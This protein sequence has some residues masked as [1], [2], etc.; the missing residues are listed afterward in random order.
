VTSTKG[1]LNLEANKFYYIEVVASRAGGNLNLALNAKMFN[2]VLTDKVSAF[3]KNEI[4][5]V[6]INSTIILESY[7][8]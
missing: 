1:N 5:D 4:Q 6:E 7:V 3:V 2:T 8:N